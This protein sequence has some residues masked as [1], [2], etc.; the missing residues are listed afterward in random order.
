MKEMAMP[1]ARDADDDFTSA[2]PVD[3]LRESG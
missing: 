2:T 3:F 1:I